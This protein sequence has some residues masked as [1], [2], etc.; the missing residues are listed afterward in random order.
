MSS[1]RYMYISVYRYIYRERGYTF[2][3]MSVCVSYLM[4]PF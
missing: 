1:F 2:V 4:G 3:R